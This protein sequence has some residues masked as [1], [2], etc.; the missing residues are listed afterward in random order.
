M[1][2]IFDIATS[3]S[4]PTRATSRL[5]NSGWRCYGGPVTTN[6]IAL[7]QEI[8]RNRVV[9]YGT[10]GLAAL[11]AWD[12]C[13][14]QFGWPKIPKIWEAT[15]AVL[16]L[17]AWLMLLLAMFV[18]GLFE[19]VRANVA[20]LSTPLDADRSFNSEEAI[21]KTKPEHGANM[22]DLSLKELGEKIGRALLK[23][24]PQATARD[25]NLEI[26]D[27]VAHNNL[28]VWGRWND[29]AIEVLNRQEVESG[30]FDFQKSEILTSNGWNGL[31]YTDV[32]LVTDEVRLIWPVAFDDN[33][34]T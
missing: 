19:Y 4:H 29:R 30:R 22:G 9:R 26:A 24:N 21:A 8:W 7:F 20:P 17:W 28:T 27:K 14:N 2:N 3:F 11:A 34:T 10:A 18:Y 6:R 13:T 25:V 23:E 12:V 32:K 5:P 15:V 31:T 1:S 33:E 16:P